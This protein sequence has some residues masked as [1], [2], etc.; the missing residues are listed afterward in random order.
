MIESML[1]NMHRT[2]I[3]TYTHT[4]EGLGPIIG[5]FDEPLLPLDTAMKPL[6][7]LFGQS[8][9]ATAVWFSKEHAQEHLHKVA[10]GG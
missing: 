10:R 9:L 1:I 6:E 7:S 8:P 4:Y 5:V 3:Y 2:Y